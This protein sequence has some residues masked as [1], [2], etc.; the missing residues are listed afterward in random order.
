MDPRKIRACGLKRLEVERRPPNILC[1][2]GCGKRPEAGQSL[3]GRCTVHG[4]EPEVLPIWE[5]EALSG[6]V[7]N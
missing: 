1:G 2:C 7:G 6:S 5:A 3:G 4:I